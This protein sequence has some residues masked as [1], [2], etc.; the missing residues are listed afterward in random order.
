A[1]RQARAVGDGRMGW[2]ALFSRAG[3]APLGISTR[4]WV[5]NRVHRLRL[6]IGC[7]FV[8]TADEIGARASRHV[9]H[10]RRAGFDDQRETIHSYRV[11]LV[12]GYWGIRD[13]CGWM[14]DSGV[15]RRFLFETKVDGATG[16]V[17]K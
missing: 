5:D 1:F 10:G 16:K 14:S 8:G 6:L 12:C 3:G 13:V 17:G 7:F 11:Y 2:L 15:I 4:S 9:R